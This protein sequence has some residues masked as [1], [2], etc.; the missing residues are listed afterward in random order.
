MDL[1]LRIV[2]I[3]PSLPTLFCLKKTGPGESNLIK[4][5]ARIKIGILKNKTNVENNKSKTLI[6]ILSLYRGKILLCMAHEY[7]S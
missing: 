4:N 1:N 2:K 7:Y 6:I 3:F 5:D